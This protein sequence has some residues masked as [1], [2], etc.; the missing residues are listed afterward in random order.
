MRVGLKAFNRIIAVLDVVQV[1]R[2]A[3]C[4]NREQALEQPLTFA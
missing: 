2:G 1:E 3:E 4:R